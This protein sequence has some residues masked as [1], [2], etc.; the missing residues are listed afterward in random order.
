M[1]GIKSLSKRQTLAKTLVFVDYSPVMSNER[2]HFP[3]IL[4]PALGNYPLVP[5]F[6]V[7]FTQG[8]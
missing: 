3:K 1:I 6:A 4:K 5:I 8:A 7:L 2:L